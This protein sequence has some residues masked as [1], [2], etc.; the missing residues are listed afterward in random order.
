MSFKK[1][2]NQRT[3]GIS[4][5][6]ALFFLF[7]LYLLPSA[8]AREVIELFSS[9][10]YIYPDGSIVVE[11]LIR[12]KSEHKKIRHGIYRLLPVKYEKGFGLK[13]DSHF[14][15]FSVK[16][17]GKPAPYHIKWPNSDEIKI[18]IGSKSRFVS[19]GV[20][21]FSL[22]YRMENMIRFFKD[23]DEIYW[24][25]TGNEWDFP[26]LK[27]RVEIVLPVRS[28]FLQYATYT[29]SYGAKGTMAHLVDKTD[30]RIVFETTRSLFRHEGFTVAVAF[31]KGLVKKPDAYSM[32]VEILRANLSIIIGFFFLALVFSIYLISWSKVGKDP[33]IGPIVPQFNPPKEIG[34]AAARF[35]RKMGY[36]DK[37]MACALVNLGVKG[38]IKITDKGGKYVLERTDKTPKEPLTGC[39]QKVFNKL[40]GYVPSITISS[41]NQSKLK[42]ARDSLEDF[43]FK[44]YEKVYFLTN[45]KYLFPGLILSLIGIFAMPL[46]SGIIIPGLFVTLWLTIWTTVTS[47]MVYRALLTFKD[48]IKSR[49]I[50]LILS[51]FG[52][53][54]FVS[55]FVGGI[56][57]GSFMYA[58]FMGVPC[59]L[60]FF[61]ILI[62]N[63]VFYHLMKAP[64]MKGVPILRELEGLKMFIEKAEANR[65]EIL[66]KGNVIETFEKLLPWAMALGVENTW[67]NKFEAYLKEHN[68]EGSYSPYWYSGSYAYSIASMSSALGSGMSSAF[69]SASVATGSGSGGGGFSGGGGGGGGGGGW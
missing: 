2:F 34:P 42:S 40:L 46:F 31:P 56:F 19:K 44:Q 27:S 16:I 41:S 26:I 61:A 25:V 52:G 50:R 24:N 62:T 9:K 28:K 58:G 69:S 5:F 11:E 3:F 53:L 60:I 49:S 22:T 17:D 35:I 51:S 36:D 1:F 33:D 38:V 59:L 45:R 32:L 54:F 20:H 6:L 14:K 21:E 48:S 18:Y 66:T 15:L 63:A 68:L 55:I 7:S 43:L 8:Q 29:G 30:Q 39:E 4:C 47:F 23:Y 64:T 12:A 65:L 13:I 57:L 10:V 37:V 67:A